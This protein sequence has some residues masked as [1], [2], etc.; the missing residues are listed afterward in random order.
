M[1]E[2]VN[3]I[4]YK[5]E[6]FAPGYIAKYGYGLSIEFIETTADFPKLEAKDIVEDSLT[7]K[8][9]LCSKEFLIYGGCVA[10]ELSFKCYNSELQTKQNLSGAKIQF[11][12]FPIAKDGTTILTQKTPLFT[13]WIE[14]VQ[15]DPITG[16]LQITAYDAFRRFQNT[17]VGDWFEDFVNRGV[18]VKEY[19]PT[20]DGKELTG[21]RA[22]AVS[23]PEQFDFLNGLA[24]QMGF[25][26]E[27][28]KLKYNSEAD[29][30]VYDGGTSPIPTDD[31][32]WH[33]FP[34][35]GTVVPLNRKA[36]NLTVIDALNQLC[37]ANGCF[38]MVSGD[39]GLSLIKLMNA[40]YE[41]ID[42]HADG[43]F[44]TSRTPD[45]LILSA[46]EYDASSLSYDE[47]AAWGPHTFVCD[48]NPCLTY[49][50][51]K[52]T[53]DQ[54]YEE[55]RYTIRNNFFIGDSDFIN[56]YF[57]C[58]E[59]GTPKNIKDV[60]PYIEKT[61]YNKFESDGIEFVVSPNVCYGPIVETQNLNTMEYSVKAY[62]DPTIKMGTNITIYLDGSKHIDSRII[63]R[64][65]NFVSDRA[66]LAEYSANSA[67]YNNCTYSDDKYKTFTADMEKT[68]KALPTVACGGSVYKLKTCKVLSKEEYDALTEKR[69]D[70]LYYVIEP[71]S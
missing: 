65:L 50:P 36:E 33:V 31:I 19:T 37:L 23:R 38:A 16:C 42:N 8:Q 68:K 20:L 52:Q 49:T 66:I 39:G 69:T 26:W 61:K 2:L 32:S 64:T 67:P 45:S 27:E 63:S 6:L 12:I 3:S 43:T 41:S 18:I 51:P 34:Y 28:T 29:V 60:Q 62:S 5:S 21:W 10:S 25:K 9:S 35:S 15:R 59:Y 71:E 22:K 14:S 40:G 7:L 44:T 24:H 46:D 54:L 55:N 13:G 47:S 56:E 57:E 48:P 30:Y 70:T 17:S 11:S 4:H 53:A 58:D 1:D